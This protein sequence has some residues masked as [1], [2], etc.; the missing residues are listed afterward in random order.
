MMVVTG[1][2]FGRPVAVMVLITALCRPLSPASAEY[3]LTI[4]VVGH[5]SKDPFAGKGITAGPTPLVEFEYDRLFGGTFSANL[6]QLSYERSLSNGFLG[7]ILVE[8][9]GAPV[10][11]LDGFDRGTAIEIGGELSYF[12]PFGV[13]TL[14]VLGDV[15][16]EHSGVEV[17]ATYAILYELADWELGMAVGAAY[18]SGGLG[19]F[20]YGVEQGDG[21]LD[22]FRVDGH[23]VLQLELSASYS[24]GEHWTILSGMTADQLPD[25]VTD[26]PVVMD[27]YE[28]LGFVGLGYTF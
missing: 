14:G 2:C 18:R 25:A 23:V 17:T 15:S 5:V 12:E 10:D 28:L 6:G 3:E 20:L 22:A 26:S 4:G 7:R 16:G 24:L 8:T 27:S 19:T 1:D 11:V 9:R 13:F 21:N